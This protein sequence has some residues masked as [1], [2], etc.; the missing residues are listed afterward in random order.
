ML[1]VEDQQVEAAC[2]WQKWLSE[3]KPRPST[4]K[5][6][7]NHA[8]SHPAGEPPPVPQFLLTQNLSP[9]DIAWVMEA[10]KPHNVI[11]SQWQERVN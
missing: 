9:K 5:P 6:R 1:E 4:A 3:Y 8:F 2:F 11:W 7:H 10:V